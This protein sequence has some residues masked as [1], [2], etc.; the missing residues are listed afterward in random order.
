MLIIENK[1]V[2]NR[3]AWCN[4]TRSSIQKNK[5]KKIDYA[6][7][8][9][10]SKQISKPHV[11]LTPRFSWVLELT[12]KHN[13]PV[14]KLTHAHTQT[15]HQQN[16]KQLLFSCG[17]WGVPVVW[18]SQEVFV[19]R[20]QHQNSRKLQQHCHGK[21]CGLKQ[22]CFFLPLIFHLTNWLPSK[23]VWSMFAPWDFLVFYLGFILF[24]YTVF[25]MDRYRGPLFYAGE[26]RK[27]LAEAQQDLSLKKKKAH[28]LFPNAQSST[29]GEPQT[30]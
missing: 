18:Q 12:V 13:N 23:I 14:Q 30:Q 11:R 6:A 5:N 2:R 21:S 27:V 1:P 25:W 9:H 29:E 26:M 20:V 15:A 16:H 19:D 8:T 28:I 22:R 24:T 10:Q 4:W 7:K 3:N 17:M